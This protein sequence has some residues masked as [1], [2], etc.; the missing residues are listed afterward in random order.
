MPWRQRSARGIDG[1]VDSNVDSNIDCEKSFVT[2]DGGLKANHQV[3]SV[4]TVFARRVEAGFSSA[5]SAPN[6][7]AVLVKAPVLANTSGGSASNRRI[8]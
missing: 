6:E 2:L 5:R 3:S 1:N 7:G 8:R 4:T